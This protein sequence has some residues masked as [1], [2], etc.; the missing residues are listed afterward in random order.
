MSG[1]RAITI[2][3]PAKVNLT[4]EVVQR[5]PNGYHG[6][7]SVMARLRPFSPTWCA[8]RCKN[9]GDGIALR[10]QFFADP[11]RRNQHLPS[12]RGRVSRTRPA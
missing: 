1:R 4:L 7:R 9:G 12:C 11:R 8:W 5:L 3:A 2:E 10:T 6:I